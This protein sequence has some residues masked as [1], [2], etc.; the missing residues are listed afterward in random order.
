VPLERVVEPYALIFKRRRDGVGREYFYGWDRLGGRSGE[1]G[2]KSYIADKVHS[3]AILEE[4]FEPLFPI[5]LT[6]SSGY[7]GSPFTS[8]PRSSSFASQ[9]TR[10]AKTTIGAS[11]KLDPCSKHGGKQRVSAGAEVSN[12]FSQA[13]FL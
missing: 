10:R 9:R 5:A 12:P 4:T 13:Q 8:P 7:F 1:V 6:K 3:V 2:I 11:R